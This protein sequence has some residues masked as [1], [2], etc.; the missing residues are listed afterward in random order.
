MSYEDQYEETSF[1]KVLEL[2]IVRNIHDHSFAVQ[3][4]S[5]GQ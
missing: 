2:Y 1:I 3:F 5:V 4:G